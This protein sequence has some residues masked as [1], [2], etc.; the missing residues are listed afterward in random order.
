[1]SKDER[2]LTLLAADQRSSLE[3]ELYGLTAPPTLAEDAR[4]SA[5]KLLIYQALLDVV[6]DLPAVV[7]PG[8]LMDEQYGAGVAELAERS[9]GAV[10]LAMPVEASGHEWFAFA[11]GRQWR[12]HAEFFALDY[13]KVL[14]RDNP[15]FEPRRRQEQARPLAEVSRW[16]VASD[17]PL[18]VELLVPP[19]AAERGTTEQE[20]DAYDLEVRPAHTVQVI[21]YLR[22]HGVEPAIW[23]VEGLDR[24]ED[25]SAVVDSARREGRP[26][27]CIVLGRHAPRSR[28]DHW[29]KV[30]AQVP[31]FVGFAIGRSIWFAALES[32][33]HHEC[34]ADEARSAI[35]RAYLDYAR[36]FLAARGLE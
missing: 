11:Y 34:S 15:A 18:I 23:K 14:I 17:R 19:T 29:L 6:E 36:Y 16:A 35:G 12:R 33:L 30:A 27:D 31:G 4:I 5:D 10:A 22:V 26:A 20:A 13:S 25:A 7:R 9:G 1:M 3:R 8:I 24:V 21:E 2:V 32:L 28:L